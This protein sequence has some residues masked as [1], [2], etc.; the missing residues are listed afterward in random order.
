MNS[1]F[2]KLILAASTWLLFLGGAGAMS[3]TATNSGGIYYSCQAKE[4]AIFCTAV[5]DY[6]AEKGYHAQIVTGAVPDGLLLEFYLDENRTH[7][8]AGRM[9]WSRCS[10]GKCGHKNET[11]RLETSV[12]DA[13]ITD[14]SFS[15]L[16]ASLFMISKP[17]LKDYNRN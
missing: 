4:Q 17:P 3:K 15:N 8:I 16:V 12:D 5:A 11:P 13:R 14:Q 1:I 9:A 6:F 2:Q 10:S 7:L